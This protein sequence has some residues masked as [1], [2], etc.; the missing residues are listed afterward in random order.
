MP[1]ESI[2]IKINDK[3]F[4]AIVYYSPAT[5]VPAKLFALPEDC[6]PDESESIEL[7]SMYMYETVCGIKIERDVSFLIKELSKDILGQINED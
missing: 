2:I 3:E 5:Y 1:H 7:I 6:H 4:E